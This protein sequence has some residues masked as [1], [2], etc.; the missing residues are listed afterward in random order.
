MFVAQGA[1]TIGQSYVNYTDGTLY[2]RAAYGIPSSPTWSTWKTNLNSGNFNTY[3]PT[4]TGGSASGNWGINIS[5]TA[6]YAN[7][8]TSNR[9]NWAGSL[10][11][12]SAVVGQL[13]WKHFGNGHTIFDASNATSPDGGAVNS[14]NP[15]VAWIPTYPT[16]M[17]WNG[18]NTYGVRVDRARFADYAY[19]ASA[20]T[21]LGELATTNGGQTQTW[22]VPAGQVNLGPWMKLYIRA[23]NVSHNGTGVTRRSFLLNGQIC[24]DTYLGTEP[25][26]GWIQ[27]D[28]A[29]GIGVF[30]DVGAASTQLISRAFN[31]TNGSTS[32]SFTTSNSNG[33]DGGVLYF[34]GVR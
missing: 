27:V 19:S 5:G 10:G 26:L 31:V 15:D 3:S 8:L 21:Y 30:A 25:W 32:M 29:T 9:N 20:M 23:I 24:S 33:F 28:L 1:D 4:L 22:T 17:G 13:S 12:I 14:S 11:V 7:N 16:L 2:S 6:S 34:Y 18:V